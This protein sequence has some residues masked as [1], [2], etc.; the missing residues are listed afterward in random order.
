[1]NDST[2]KSSPHS[3]NDS[4]PLFTVVTPAYNLQWLDETIQSVRD[5]TCSN[6]VYNLVVSTGA[7]EGVRA[8]AQRHATRDPRI[9]V[10]NGTGK[11]AS[12][13]R[14][15]G[16]NTIEEGTVPSPYIALL[17]D[18]DLWHPTLLEKFNQAFEQQ[19]DDVIGV[20]GRVKIFGDI[21]DDIA[22]RA[23]LVGDN[24]EE[25]FKKTGRLDLAGLLRSD[26]PLVCSSAFAA[27]REALEREPEPFKVSAEPNEDYELSARLLANNPGTY[28]YGIDET[29]ISYRRRPGQGS[30]NIEQVFDG[31]GR[32]Y[33][34]YLPKVDPA[35]RQAVYRFAATCAAERGAP[36][37][38]VQFHNNADHAMRTNQR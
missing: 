13:C 1:M 35:T 17:D 26:H 38:A 2:L 18:D 34:E 29:L 30:R 23:K 36:V 25:F 21:E 24:S 16:I 4:E 10:V 22:T 37:Q 19:G 14:N 12:T 8:V 20:Y 5:Q 7:D 15:D 28:V 31:I 11:K 3:F 27:R 33:D 32:I 9:R 6:F